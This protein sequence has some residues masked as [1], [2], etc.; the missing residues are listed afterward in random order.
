ME[1]QPSM[2]Q[3]AFVV[4]VFEYSQEVIKVY[5]EVLFEVLGL[6]ERDQGVDVI[7]HFLTKDRF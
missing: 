5:K 4:P 2:D 6:R 1:K 3:T 7:K